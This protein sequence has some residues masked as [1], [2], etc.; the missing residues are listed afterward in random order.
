MTSTK[1]PPAQ[2]PPAKSPPPAPLDAEDTTALPLSKA[3]ALAWKNIRIRWMRS[4]LVT[5]GIVLALSFL[6]YM[7]TADML[8]RGIQTGG[9]P[10]LVEDLTKRGLLATLS[11]ADA[12]AQSWWMVGLALLISF[13]GILNAMVMS[14]TERF[15]EI[16]TMKCLG[17]YDSFIIRIYF[18]ESLFQGIV[19]TCAGIVV[20]LALA[21]G[22]GFLVYGGEA[23]GVTRAAAL[24]RLIGFAFLSGMV[25]TVA[26]AIYPAWRAARM[27]P[28]EAMRS[29]V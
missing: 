11:D 22:E 3:V 26:G 10:Q 6:T 17:A 29:E 28:V 25:L 27:Q 2:T 19:G 15:R 8:L 9:S 20:G 24:G 12:R 14:V 18:L 1:P 21:Y 16:G 7:L 23:A 4:M 13:V 5:S